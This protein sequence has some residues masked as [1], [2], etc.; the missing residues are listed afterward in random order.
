MPLCLYH[1]GG[2][3]NWTTV[4][5]MGI[6]FQGE[7]CCKLPLPLPGFPSCLEKVKR[8]LERFIWRGQEVS[9][10]Q[11]DLLG[12]IYPWQHW[13]Y[14]DLCPPKDGA[15]Y[16]LMPCHCLQP[17]LGSFLFLF[18]CVEKRDNNIKPW[19]LTSPKGTTFKVSDGWRSK[20][21]LHCCWFRYEHRKEIHH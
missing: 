3:K 11:F 19:F 9:Y 10:A 1:P 6:C 16:V 5:E 7:I 15:H 13:S 2:Q 8:V 14:I 12:W 18:P 4:Q 17:S 21:L 20:Q